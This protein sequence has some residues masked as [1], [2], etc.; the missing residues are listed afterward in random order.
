MVHFL[1]GK[2][3]WPAAVGL[4]SLTV[5]GASHMK[6]DRFR[7]MLLQNAT[8][9]CMLLALIALLIKARKVMRHRSKKAMPQLNEWYDVNTYPSTSNVLYFQHN[10]LPEPFCGRSDLFCCLDRSFFELPTWY[11]LWHCCEGLASVF[12]GHVSHHKGFV[13]EL[14]HDLFSW[15]LAYLFLLVYHL[16]SW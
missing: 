9:V 11:L 10:L 5:V 16:H 4:L 3:G 2:L 14:A 13:F 8:F 15:H 1:D 7:R 6:P 12:L